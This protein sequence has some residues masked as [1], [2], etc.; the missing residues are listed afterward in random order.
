[1][2]KKHRIN[3]RLDNLSNQTEV[4]KALTNIRYQTMSE[5]EEGNND[6]DKLLNDKTNE[7]KFPRKI[8]T[9]QP[10]E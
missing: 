8:L 1:M 9:Y 7:K 2:V 5:N 6:T 4:E 10:S 3:I